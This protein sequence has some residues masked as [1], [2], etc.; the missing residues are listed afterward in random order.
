MQG[1][2]QTSSDARIHNCFDHTIASWPISTGAGLYV[3]LL[4]V[5]T[6]YK[7]IGVTT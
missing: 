2:I 5:V 6:R 3:H 1:H 4:I 7:L